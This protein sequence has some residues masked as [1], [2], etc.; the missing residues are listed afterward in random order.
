MVFLHGLPLAGDVVQPVEAIIRVRTVLK[1]FQGG[2]GNI[3]S[4]GIAI[5]NAKM[6]HILIDKRKGQPVP[7]LS[8]NS[9]KNFRAARHAP[10]AAAAISILAKAMIQL[11]TSLVFAVPLKTINRISTKP[12]RS[13]RSVRLSFTPKCLL[14]MSLHDTGCSSRYRV[15]KQWL[16]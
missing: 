11:L 10:T 1:I 13:Q 7:F 2:K 4:N 5:F 3:Y 8:K 16:C 14:W 15:L 9:D 12:V 6:D